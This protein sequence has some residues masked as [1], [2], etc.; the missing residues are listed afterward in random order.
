MPNN[1]VL[2]DSVANN[3]NQLVSDGNNP[4]VVAAAML[5]LSLQFYKELLTEEEYIKFVN[6]I[7]FQM[8]RKNKDKYIQ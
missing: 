3:F 7:P 1:D 8:L 2:V 5:S 4:L 6:N